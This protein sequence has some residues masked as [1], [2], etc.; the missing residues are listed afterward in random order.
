MVEMRNVRLLKI[1]LS[2]CALLCT[3]V[4][5][6]AQ[7]IQVGPRIAG[8]E[9]NEE[10]MSLLR[11]DARLQIREDSIVGAVETMRRHLRE[12]PSVQQ[13]YSQEILELENRIFE[14]RNARGRLIDRI[15]TIEQEWVLNSLNAPTPRAAEAK[16]A[17]IVPDSLQKRNL[18]D[19]AVFREQ[20]PAADYAALRRAQRLEPRAVEYVNR[21]FVNYGTVSELANAYAAAQTETEA[22]EI[23]DRYT[24]LQDENRAIGDSLSGAWNYIFDNKSYAFGYL[25]DKLREDETLARE[26]EALS[27]AARRMS[28]LRGQTASDAVADYFLRKYVLVDYETAVAGVLGLTAASDSLRAVAA[29]L[30]EGEYLLPKVE[31]TERYFL[32]YDSVAFSSTP[33]YSTRNPIPECKIYERG[34]IYRILLGRFNTKRA[35]STFRGAYPLFY[36]VD[37]EKKWCYYTGGFATRAEADEAQ[38]RLKRHGFVRPEVVVWTDG[39]YRNLSREPETPV[40]YRVEITGTEALSDAVKGAIAQH[41]EGVEFSRVGQLFVVGTFADRV[42]ADRV[43]EAVRQADPELEIKVVEAAE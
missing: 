27:Q 34:T 29:Q 32:D 3:A 38:Q 19:N 1:C 11:D 5:P 7:E 9:R 20:L 26:E 42:V 12:D 23:F 13:R 6:R 18:V 35:V 33:K 15:N 22:L 40:T 10:Y 36:L 8:L 17:A 31:I 25:L 43:A 4:G 16:T 37:D 14:V 24:L 30:G 28:S 39:E 2:A 41:A 21:Y